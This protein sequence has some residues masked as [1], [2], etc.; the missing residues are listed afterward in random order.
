MITRKELIKKYIEF[1][2]SKDHKE[3]PNSSLIPENDPTV[4][5]TTAG[6][7]PLV[8]F[9]LGQKH[10]LG[11]R[12]VNV[13]KCIRTGDIEEVGDEVHHTFFEMLG[14]W[15]LGDYWK[16][17]AI[18]FAY[19]FLTKEIK[20]SKEKISVTCFKGDKDAPK[21]TESEE[22]WQSLGIKKIKFLP[23]EDN[24]WGPAGK[25]GPC[26]P[27]TEVFV[28][29]V[30][31]WNCGVF[32][33]YIKDKRLILVDG[34]DCVYDEDFK[35]NEE[36]LKIINN[37]NTHTILTVNGFREKG[38]NLIK[39]QSTG[40]DTNWKAF[41]LEEEKI[42]KE[43]PEYFNTLL[44]RFNL[45]PEE[46]IYFD[47]DKNS[48]KTAEKLGILSKHYTDIN[49]IK[50]FIEDNLW[51]FIPAK[52]KNIDTG[53]GVERTIALLNNL[54]DNYLTEC[55]KPLINKIESISGKKYES[56]K[57]EFR[58]IAD[59]MKAAVFILSDGITPSNTEQGYVLRRLIRR[60]IRYGQSLGIKENFTS[61]LV[62]SV[63]KIYPE[64]TELNENKNN[65]V[66]E[67][68]R[69]ENKF[70]QTLERGINIFERITQGKNGISCK[71]SFLLYQSYG[72]PVEMIEEECKARKIKF[73]RAEFEGECKIHQELSRTAAAGK[74]KSGLADNSEETTRLH[75]TAHLLLAAIRKILKDPSIHQKGSN[76]T[77]ERL[78]FDFNFPRKLTD[79]EIREIE[80]E[81]NSNIKKG[82]QVIREEMPLEEAKK[83]GISGVF[84]HK[85]GEIVSI[86]TIGECSKEICAGPH[87]KNTCDLGKFK[88]V[89]EESSSSGVRRIKGILE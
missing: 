46:V 47:H 75:T 63:I 53:M 32:M 42:K 17:E 82:C 33:E 25:T 73:S 5:F 9:L 85:Y 19:D 83:K 6:M 39:S 40:Y 13:Q 50:K 38:Y 49:S 23:K 52:Q 20:V 79:E 59:H 57:K 37:F 15:S 87:V 45:V 78:R 74:F 31:I 76:I 4:L 43:N 41:S 36:L 16:K 18:E 55:F 8:P 26:G 80:D 11:K 34:M 21:D 54:N 69:E 48:I 14:Q 10:P 62:D 68:D 1:F 61:K 30:E 12:L 65:I 77:A 22:I 60:S 70:R 27:D 28:N 72:F 84:E 58:I 81:V 71:D 24:W 66:T 35:I 56:N 2:K 64:Y 3:I 67:L 44:K 7:H 29:N 86:Y 88:I 51:V 89:K